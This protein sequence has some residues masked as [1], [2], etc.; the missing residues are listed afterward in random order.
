M[1]KNYVFAMATLFVWTFLLL[2][3]T[4]VIFINGGKYFFFL[5]LKYGGTVYFPDPGLG[6]GLARQY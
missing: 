3:A 6:I 4:A 5:L 2:L 1:Q